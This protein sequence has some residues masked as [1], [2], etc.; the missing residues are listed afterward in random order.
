MS[1]SL[2][3]AVW[4]LLGGAAHAGGSLVW[5]VGSPDP[6]FH[7]EL[8]GVPLTRVAPEVRSV[9]RD[10]AAVEALRAELEAVRP[11]VDEF[12]GEL[13]IMS[14]L[15]AVIGDLPT[16][17]DAAT[18]ELLAS[19]LTFQG[20]A[21]SRYFQDTLAT[22]PA[23]APYRTTLG[24]VVVP[25]AWVD[26]VGVDPDRN[27]LPQDLPDPD[28]QRAF[29][30]VRAAVRIAPRATV[31]VDVLPAQAALVV[32]GRPPDLLGR[33]YVPP[34]QHWAQV[35]DAEGAVLARAH[36]RVASGEDLRVELAPSPQDFAELAAEL[37]QGPEGWA[38][39]PALREALAPLPPPVFLAVPTEDGPWLYEVRGSAAVRIEGPEPAGSGGE[40]LALYAGLGG[41]WVYDGEYYLQHAD[42]APYTRGTVNAP[43]VVATAGARLQAGRWFAADA[44]VDLGL[45]LGEYSTL[46]SGDRSLRA[47]AHPYAAVGLPWVQ[48]SG[49]FFFPWHAAAG[50]RVTV[51][52]GAHLAL[53]GAAVQG[54]GLERPRAEGVEPFVPTDARAAWLGV[55]GRIGR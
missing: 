43:A 29:D 54:F 23:A 9:A 31:G 13:L 22:D 45:P 47:R 11:L 39:D 41:G 32:D 14:R 17:P 36:A 38:L 51:P 6:T 10:A 25:Q 46:Q 44:G 53:A 18:R 3:A 35:V 19:A 16:V 20:Y 24:G 5:L 2:L 26:A 30:E 12:D 42:S 8:E 27:P 1:L 48:V 28:A 49:G 33:V 40:G 37:A 55:Q 52:L 21:V 7:P 34:G 50:L 15:E 4:G